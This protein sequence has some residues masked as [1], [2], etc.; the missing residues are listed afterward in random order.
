MKPLIN[1]EDPAG[2]TVGRRVRPKDALEYGFALQKS[3][4]QLYGRLPIRRG[5]Y[6]FHSHEEA[7]AWMMNSLTRRTDD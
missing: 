2:K 7:D 5:V 1:L 6:R 4:H 3:L